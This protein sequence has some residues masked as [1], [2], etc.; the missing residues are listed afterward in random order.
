MHFKKGVFHLFG[1]T[2][3]KLFFFVMTTVLITLMC[4]LVSTYNIFRTLMIDDYATKLSHFTNQDAIRLSAHLNFLSSN[5]DNICKE[6]ELKNETDSLRV[7][8]YITIKL[9]NSANYSPFI[10][11]VYVY[12]NGMLV[13]YFPINSKYAK[14]DKVMSKILNHSPK[15]DGWM[16]NTAQNAD[17]SINALYYAKSIS[18]KTQIIFKMNSEDIFKTFNSD[19][20]FYN[21]TE[22]II[23]SENRKLLLRGKSITDVISKNTLKN[24]LSQKYISPVCKR[25]KIIY[26]QHVPQT[27]FYI[28]SVTKISYINQKMHFLMSTLIVIYI[29]AILLC[30]FFTM[31]LGN[32]ITAAL[33]KIHNDIEHYYG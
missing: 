18:D 14:P 16:I 8:N 23:F 25:G 15:V 27:E 4:T 31:K 7:P 20:P 32:E 10:S 1:A 6:L 13:P 28:C 9:A 22:M 2:N 11:S 17:K 5:M 12:Q 29:A 21:E 19:T 3:K 26:T 33:G 24:V 30:R